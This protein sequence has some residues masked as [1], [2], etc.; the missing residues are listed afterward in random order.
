MDASAGWA[1]FQGEAPE[2]ARSVLQRL[3]ARHHHVLGTIRPDGSPRL[4]GTE[5]QFGTWGLAIG[6]MPETA[7]GRDLE[8]DGRFALHSH[9]AC[10]GLTDPDVKMWGTAYQIAGDALADYARVV[11]PPDQFVAYQLALS[12]VSRVQVHPDGDRLIIT[13]WRPGS[14]VSTVE[15]R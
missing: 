12:G 4:S 10:E 7:K 5:V 14:G 9:P 2:L 6:F 15:R 11:H 8:R 1:R 13:T 3:Q